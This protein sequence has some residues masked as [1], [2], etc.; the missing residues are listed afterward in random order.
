M[1]ISRP[2]VYVLIKE[3][4]EKYSKAFFKQASG[5]NYDSS[6]MEMLLDFIATSWSAKLSE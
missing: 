2:L 3:Q 4:K 1:R 5:T 6:K